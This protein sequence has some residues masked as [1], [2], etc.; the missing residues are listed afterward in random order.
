MRGTGLALP[1]VPCYDRGARSCNC[2]VSVKLVRPLDI[3]VS[4]QD[5]EALLLRS[6]SRGVAARVPGAAIAVLTFCGSPRSE[7]EVAETFGPPYR[8]LFQALARS[9]F[10]VDPAKADSFRRA[11]NGKTRAIFVE[12]IGNPVLDVVDLEAVAKVA[13]EHHLPLVVDATFTTPY[14]LKPLEHG[15]DV[16]CHSLTNRVG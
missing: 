2:E 14:L 12:T 5:D 9:G 8:Q 6:A 3:S 11:I 4:F 1:S 15:A 7:D 10:L 13:Q 16:V